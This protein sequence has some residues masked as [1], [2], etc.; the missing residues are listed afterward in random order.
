[1]DRRIMDMR[2]T[3]WRKTGEANR[4]ATWQRVSFPCHWEQRRGSYRSVNGQE[5]EWRVEVICQY[6]DAREGDRLALG[7]VASA[8][9]P[10]DAY[11]VIWTD[12][13]PLRGRAHHYEVYAG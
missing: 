2:C 1:M 12:M 8:N 3:L 11:T 10:E 4:T 7:D 9:P 5:S 13:L 6:G